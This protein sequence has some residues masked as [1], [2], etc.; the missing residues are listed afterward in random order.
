MK[1]KKI[2]P[3]VGWK[4]MDK[5]IGEVI[6]DMNKEEGIQKI[7]KAFQHKFDPEKY[8][9]PLR[10]QL[11]LYETLKKDHSPEEL[12]PDKKQY[13]INKKN[14]KLKHFD[15]KLLI[16]KHPQRAHLCACNWRYHSKYNKGRIAEHNKTC[17]VNSP[18]GI[19][20]VYGPENPENDDEVVFPFI[21]YKQRLDEN[22]CMFDVKNRKIEFT[23]GNNIDV[24]ATIIRD[25][26]NGKV[27]IKAMNDKCY[28]I[29]LK[30]LNYHN[31]PEIWR[32]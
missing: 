28:T 17:P 1:K 27:R 30:A 3:R 4:D 21:G 29:K 18:Y 8:D 32:G 22:K 20:P 31:T 9:K 6:D 19:V 7:R 12:F 25:V 11:K 13:Y 24:T 15:D 5:V 16:Y 26:G 10:E 14:E 23:L 2:I